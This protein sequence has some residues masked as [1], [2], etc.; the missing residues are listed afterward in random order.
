[1]NIRQIARVCSGYLLRGA[2]ISG[3]LALTAYFLYWIFRT[4]D[5]LLPIGI[6]GLGLVL[7]LLLVGSVGFFSSNVI[8]AGILEWLERLLRRV[9]FVKLVYSSIKDLVNA[10][11]GDKKSFDKPVLVRLSAQSPL[12]AL[13]FVTRQTLSG[14]GLSQHSAVYFPQSYNFA[15]NLLLVPVELIEPLHVSS[16]EVMTFIVSGGVSGFGIGASMLPAAPTEPSS[17]SDVA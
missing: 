12:R 17:A 13:G 3:P 2:L 11:V 16:G 8:G 4:V 1:M 10:F 7:T 15:G 14:L 5:Q 9:P 6:P